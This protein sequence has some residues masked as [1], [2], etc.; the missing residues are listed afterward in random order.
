MITSLSLNHR[1]HEN[2]MVELREKEEMRLQLLE[3]VMTAQEEERKRI[4]RELHDGTS[5]ALT[6]LMVGLIVLESEASFCEVGD[7]LQEMR[8][9][10]AQTL[11]AVSYTHLRAHETRHDLVCR[12]LLE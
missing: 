4:S 3:K 8:Q 2:L 7:R 10:V 11:E 12:L 9:T 6:S 1:E 5:Q